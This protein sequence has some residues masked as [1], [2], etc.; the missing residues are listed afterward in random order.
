MRDRVVDDCRPENDEQHQRPEFDS[1]RKSADD[2]CRGDAGE[3]HLEDDVRIF[4]D[5]DL[6]RKG[7]CKRGRI[8]PLEECLAKAADELA[9]PG[10]GHRIAPADPHQGGDAD[11]RKNLH[12]H[13]KH[14]LGSNKAAVEQGEARHR[15]HQYQG[16]A[17]QHPRSVALVDHVDGWLERGGASRRGL[18]ESGRRSKKSGNAASGR[19]LRDLRNFHLH[20]F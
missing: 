15:H 14:V 9:S 11:N 6:V 1:L 18:G 12:Q 10:K 20:L 2:Q 4:G 13:R 16:G 7:R 8:D 5:V 19:Q 17:H 3:S